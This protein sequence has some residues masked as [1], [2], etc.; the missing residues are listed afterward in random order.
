MPSTCPSCGTAVVRSDE[1]VAIRCPNRSC[2][3]QLKAHLRHLA[4]K[5]NLDIDGLGDKLVAQLVDRGLVASIPDL[6]RL[7]AA[8]LAELDRMGEKSAARITTSIEI[9]KTRPLPRWIAA[10]G[11][12]HVGAVVA[13]TIADHARTL[14]GFRA[15][16]R[17][18]LVSMSDVGDIVADA[19]AH[20]LAD[21]DHAAMLDALAAA[22]VAPEP[23]KAKAEGGPLRGMTA[24]VTGTLEGFDRRDA[25]QWL[26]DAGAKVAGSVSKATTF[27]LAGEKA[28][29]KLDK[30]RALGV[31]VLDL[32]T[33]RAWLSGGPKPF[34]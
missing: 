17:E 2:P 3:E 14:D 27:V 33:V 9:A 5:D 26:K 1:E 31:P 21:P 30:A 34:A 10:F 29:S 8:T 20:W 32:E 19:V 7:D 6:F 12:R 15:L 13:A 24:V 22:G 18:Q 23:P 28:G 25:E 16:S 4:W 11:I